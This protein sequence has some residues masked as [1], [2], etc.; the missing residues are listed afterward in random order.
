M[1]QTEAA[2]HRIVAQMGT[3]HR[4]SLCKHANKHTHL[5]HAYMQ[6]VHI[7]IHASVMHAHTHTL[8]H[9]CVLDFE[10]NAEWC[11][12]SSG[13]GFAPAMRGFVRLFA[14]DTGVLGAALFGDACSTQ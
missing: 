12:L 10:R 14:V 4:G 7:S 1:A 13:S 11:L 3:H 2:G 8:A 9:V 6:S 5:L